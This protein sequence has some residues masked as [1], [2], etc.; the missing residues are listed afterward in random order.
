MSDPVYPEDETTTGDVAPEEPEAGTPG[1]PTDPAGPQGSVNDPNGTGPTPGQVA[2]GPLPDHPATGPGEKWTLTAEGDYAGNE[3]LLVDQLRNALAG[4][5]V[6][7][8]TLTTS[9]G[10]DID[11]SNPHI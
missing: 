2:N 7:S 8:A 10:E 3:Y 5:G 1:N 4:F 11:V 9:W 6:Q